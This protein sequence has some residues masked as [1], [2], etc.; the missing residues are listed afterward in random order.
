MQ[1]GGGGGDILMQQGTY[2]AALDMQD[3]L[4]LHFSHKPRRPLYDMALV[5]V[6]GPLFHLVGPLRNCKFEIPRHLFLINSLIK[7]KNCSQNNDV[8]GYFTTAAY[9]ILKY[10]FQENK[11]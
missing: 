7:T 11:T 8:Q 1:S 4:G 5:S 10:F 2:Q 3:D 9:T 6:L